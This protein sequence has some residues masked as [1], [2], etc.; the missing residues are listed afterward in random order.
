MT[1]PVQNI[2]YMRVQEG[3]KAK[4]WGSILG[5]TFG[6]AASL[7]ISDFSNSWNRYRKSRFNK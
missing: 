6:L 7:T 2:E 1:I 4:K 5:I 3:N